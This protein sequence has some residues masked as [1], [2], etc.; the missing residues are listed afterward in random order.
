M[1]NTSETNL[2]REIILRLG[3]IPGIRVFRNNTGNAWIGKSYVV[4]KAMSINVNKGDVVVYQA[5]FFTA[6]LCKGSSDIIGFKSVVITPE[7]VG[8]T[9]AIFIAPEVK[10][11]TG[12]I[13]PE[14][15]AFIN[16]VN[17]FGG[18]AAIVKSEAEAEEIFK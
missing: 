11:A 12:K 17:R 14:Q 18:I 13:S 16:T 7:M 1:S 8:K 10:T 2:V 9:V 4:P 15:E 3:R 5:R 6:G